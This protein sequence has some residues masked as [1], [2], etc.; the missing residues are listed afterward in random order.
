[1]IRAIALW[2]RP[3]GWPALPDAV[4][5]RVR[6]L[7]WF[8]VA[9]QFFFVA[10]WIVAGALEPGYSPVHM[11]VSELGRRGAA[12]PWI[13]DLSTVVLGAGL[14]AIG[15]AILPGLRGRPWGWAAPALFAAAGVLTILVGPLRLDCAASVSHICSVRQAAGTLSWHHYAHLWLSL[16]IQVLL[17]LTPFALARAE[18]PSR[19]GVLTLAG[20]LEAA[21]LLAVAFAFH[22]NQGA[23]V[24]LWQ[25]VGLL[26]VHGW[27]VA[28]ATAV[29]V[30]ASP[31]WPPFVEPAPGQVALEA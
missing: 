11:Y 28:C 3:A 14:M 2:L 26:I 29:I 22:S 1:M 7:G 31:G 13:F 23:S 27:V 12:N 25:R 9:A 18:W 4:R 10:C 20:G 24:G 15:L 8:A 30:E 21:F 16:A 5:G 17:L 19:L 6:A